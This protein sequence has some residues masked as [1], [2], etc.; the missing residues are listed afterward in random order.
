M[1]LV[2]STL[3]S[4]LPANDPTCKFVYGTTSIDKQQLIKF[5]LPKTERLIEVGFVFHMWELVNKI[6]F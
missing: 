1:V 2:S 3:T 5:T 6:E 4:G